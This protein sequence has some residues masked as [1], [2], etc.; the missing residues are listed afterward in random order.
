MSFHLSL[1]IELRVDV[2]GGLDTPVACRNVGLFSCEHAL[3]LIQCVHVKGTFAFLLFAFCRERV[4]IFAR[5]NCAK[6]RKHWFAAQIGGDVVRSFQE[7]RV[8]GE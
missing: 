7:E 5:V 8:V 1:R 6:R 4:G 3:Y 2:A